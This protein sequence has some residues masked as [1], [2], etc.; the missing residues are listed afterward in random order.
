MRKKTDKTELFESMPIPKAVL[1]LAVPTV[2]SIL[3]TLLYNLADT[4]FVGLL[5]DPIQNA[6][7]TLAAPVLLAFNAVNNLFGTGCSS[8]MSR[9]LGRKDAETAQRCSSFG[10]WCSLLCGVL[11]SALAAVFQRPLLA[12]LGASAEN[13]D[14]AAAYMHWTVSLG[15]APAIL[16]VVLAYFVRAEGSSIHASIGTMCGC[17][18][19]ILIDPFFILPWGLNMGAAG[20]GCATF[21]S[22]C[23]ACA[24]FLIL[25]CVR[26]GRTIVSLNPK[27]FRVSRE[28][29]RGV[30]SI[31]IPSA[32]QNLFNVISLAVLTR[33]ATAYGSEAVSAMGIANKVYLVPLYTAM[34]IALGLMPLVS[35]NYSS[36]NSERLKAAVR[37][38][39][40]IAVAFVAAVAALLCI[41]APQVVRL[42]IRNDTIIEYGT[43]YLRGLSLGLPFFAIDILI[44]SSVFNAC[45]MGGRALLFALLRKVV[46]QIPLLILLNRFFPPYG[47]AYAELIAELF[48]AIVALVTL[49]N[50]FRQLDR[51]STEVRQEVQP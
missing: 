28:V 37:Y 36:G 47:I 34:G 7:V 2:A 29:S 22:N 39:L 35:Y 50:I 3:V 15:A 43:H 46:L 16:N 8:M 40:R 17:F 49:R 4:W 20:A 10:F 1:T 48:L 32:L 42:F 31:G 13:H 21:L 6:A 45:G 41:F 23:V 18:L 51:K 44:V 5:N 33:F 27:Q 24:Y 12:S 11:F 30:F 14:A 25:I 19:N 38:G 26:R 9:A